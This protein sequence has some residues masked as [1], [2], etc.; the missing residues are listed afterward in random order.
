MSFIQQ[1]CDCDLLQPVSTAT[2]LYNVLTDL[3]TY[4][5]LLSVQIFDCSSLRYEVPIQT[6]RTPGYRAADVDYDIKF[7]NGAFGFAV[8][9][10][11][12]GAILSVLL[13]IFYTVFL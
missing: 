11:S 12:S 10:K 4:V 8:T 6:P 2:V 3:F 7:R 1:I 9:R 5:K 13:M